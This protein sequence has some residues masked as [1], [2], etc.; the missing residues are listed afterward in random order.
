MK[1]EILFSASY[2]EL[3]Y[4]ENVEVNQLKSLIGMACCESSANP[5]NMRKN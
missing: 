4:D 3:E 5:M 2:L 1:R